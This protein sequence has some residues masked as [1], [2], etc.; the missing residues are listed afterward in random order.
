[1]SSIIP[2][3][4][5]QRSALLTLALAVL[6]AAALTLA[7]ELVV[8]LATALFLRLTLAVLRA[9]LQSAVSSCGGI[10]PR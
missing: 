4:P 6:A 9:A 10:W 8:V 1:M 5:S 7:L 3:P 2:N